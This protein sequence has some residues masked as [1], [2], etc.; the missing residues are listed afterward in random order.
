M[1][2]VTLTLRHDLG[3]QVAPERAARTHR[4]HQR[5]EGAHAWKGGLLGL[6][7]EEVCRWRAKH[8]GFRLQ[9]LKP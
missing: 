8:K 2:L 9:G 6:T 3:L 7:G 1:V 5:R 4:T